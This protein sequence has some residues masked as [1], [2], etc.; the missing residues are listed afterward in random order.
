MSE[1]DQQPSHA[2]PAPRKTQRAPASC[3]ACTARKVK[4]EKIFPCK[5]CISKGI[6]D[7]CRREVRPARSSSSSARALSL[8][9]S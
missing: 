1:F 9:S 6:G 5:R 3:T 2:G 4:C 8:C 7:E